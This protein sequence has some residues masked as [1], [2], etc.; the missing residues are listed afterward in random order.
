[1]PRKI[2]FFDHTAELGGGEIALLNL[3]I[4][5]DRDEFFPVVVLGSDGPFRERLVEAGIE[6]HIVPLAAAVG[7]TRKDTLGGGSILRW[8]EAGLALAYCFKLARFIRS[9][10]A[11]L[12][13]TN[14]LKADILGGVAS[15]LARV[16]VVWHVRDRIETDYLPKTVVVVFRRLCRLIP[17]F[18]IANSHATLQTLGLP[19]DTGTVAYIG[20]VVHDGIPVSA[21]D[22]RKTPSA[23]PL[24]ALVGRISAWKG[25]HIFIAPA[26][27]VRERFPQARF[28]IIGSAMFGEEEYE[29]EIRAQ[30][31]ALGLQ[32]CLEF[33]GFRADVP[34]LIDALDILVH[35]STSGE[36]FG[37]VVIEGMAAGK[38]VVA[39]N[40]GGIPE[41]MR[42][43]ET[44]ILVPM[45][46][47]PAMAE[48]L[49][50]LLAEPDTAAAMGAAGRR[51]VLAH[52]T[53]EHTARKVEAVFR[54][55]ARL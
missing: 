46:D 23:T 40:G 55:H 37:Q 13:H 33:T 49:I 2:L 12:V 53:A 31:V 45:G 48:A 18:V 3:V 47:A 15:R 7:G 28:Q 42:D 16:P 11:A 29:K 9:S 50:R 30:S 52:F 5:L 25:Q 21:S 27:R 10:R 24:I 14:S 6:T 26:A 41:I 39:T 51:R 19:K 35:A 20:I 34:E 4:R 22:P 54:E 17:N 43:D 1:M 36:P 44:G 8:R 38:P 32:D